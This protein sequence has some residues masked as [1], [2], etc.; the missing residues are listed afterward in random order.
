MEPQIQK[1]LKRNQVGNDAI[2]SLLNSIFNQDR[3]SLRFILSGGSDQPV[4]L[5]HP[6]NLNPDRV[7]HLREIEKVAKDYRLRF[8]SSKYFKDEIPREAL[9]KWRETKSSLGMENPDFYILAPGDKFRRINK[10]SDPLLFA[11][12]GNGFYYLIHAWG[13]D[14]SPWRKILN[15]PYRSFTNLL[16]SI[17]SLVL[18]LSL[19]LPGHWIST[20]AELVPLTRAYLFFYL[21][22]A[23][24]GLTLFYSFAL[25]KNFSE[26]TWNSKYL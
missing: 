15:W 3:D 22:I 1:E 14:L 26:N 18:I 16:L 20:Q 10:D 8:L 23:V 21:F 19:I 25:N 9:V 5:N 24:G 13:N 12:L 11:N 7:Y 2:Q 6:E 4:S 17:A